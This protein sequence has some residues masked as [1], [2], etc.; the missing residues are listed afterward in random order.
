MARGV[1]RDRGRWRVPEDSSGDAKRLSEPPK[2]T[3]DAGPNN[4]IPWSRHHSFSSGADDGYLRLH[5]FHDSYYVLGGELDM[6]EKEL[7]NFRQRPAPTWTPQ[8]VTTTTTTALRRH[9]RRSVP[10]CWCLALVP[11]H[12]LA[13]GLRQS[14]MRAT[15]V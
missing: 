10:Q 6:S 2:S 5:H 8:R 12:V 14:G 15:L 11:V 4:S 13:A 9:H 7:E 1:R 3:C